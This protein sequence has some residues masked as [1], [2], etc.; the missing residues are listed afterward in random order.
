MG[1]RRY[2]W[3]L[4]GTQAKMFKIRPLSD[5]GLTAIFTCFNLGFRCSLHPPKPRHYPNPAIRI[6]EGTDENKRTH[7]VIPIPLS[8]VSRQF[9]DFVETS[10]GTVHPSG[11]HLILPLGEVQ[12]I[13][14]A[15]RAPNYFDLDEVWS[16]FLSRLQLVD[17]T[18]LS[19]IDPATEP[20]FCALDLD[21]GNLVYPIPGGEG[22]LEVD[23]GDVR[24]PRQ[25]AGS[26]PIVGE[27][28][29]ALW[30]AF[31]GIQERKEQ[32]ERVL[33][34]EYRS[35]LKDLEAHRLD[36]FVP[37]ECVADRLLEGDLA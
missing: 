8:E 26:L 31:S 13:L 37:E 36:S 32:G 14:A 4:G 24:N 12:R 30:D 5:G 18:D 28:F 17:G 21:T 7:A 34:P 35:A 33:T 10:V 6:S 22:Y 29:G 23:L 27:A 1:N 19:S 15:S 2:G 16:S 3:R 20:M 11:R 25:L 9:R